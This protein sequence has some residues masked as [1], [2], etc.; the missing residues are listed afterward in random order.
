M[1]LKEKQKARGL[2]IRSATVASCG[3]RCRGYG[4]HCSPNK[5]SETLILVLR[6]PCLFLF[7][8]EASPW[9]G[10]V[11]IEGDSSPLTKHLWKHLHRPAESPRQFQIQPS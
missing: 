4:P 9:V 7:S 1:Q 6:S 8:L 3:D 11:H 10:T 5:E 2:R